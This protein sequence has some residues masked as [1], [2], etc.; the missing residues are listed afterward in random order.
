MT[1]QASIRTRRPLEQGLGVCTQSRD[2]SPCRGGDCPGL[3]GGY[4]GRGWDGGRSGW[5]GVCAGAQGVHPRGT[6][7]QNPRRTR[8]H[9]IC[10]ARRWCGGASGAGKRGRAEGGCVAVCAVRYWGRT[11]RRPYGASSCCCWDGGGRRNLDILC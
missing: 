7:C 4:H 10:R 8:W 3:C 11:V 1:S 9:G 2:L 5:C 6:R